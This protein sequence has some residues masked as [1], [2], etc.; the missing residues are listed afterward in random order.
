MMVITLFK[1]TLLCLLIATLTANIKNT[2]SL[3][4]VGVVI[5][6]FLMGFDL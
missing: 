4:S 5:L 1:D 6:L 3:L 2:K